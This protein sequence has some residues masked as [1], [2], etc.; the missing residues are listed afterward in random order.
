MIIDL[1]ENAEKYTSVHKRI[2]KAFHYLR[3]T[4]L[5]EAALGKYAIDGD[6]VFAI[7]Q[8]YKTMDTTNEEM[9]THIKYIDVQYMIKGEELVGHALLN[10]QTPSKEYDA[11]NDFM[12]FPDTPSFFTKMETG[13]FMVFFPTD[14]HMPCIKVHDSAMVKKIVVKVKV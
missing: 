9:E 3:T 8:E 14:M 1:L 2:G 11:D 4:D 12:L 7:V 10:G 6:D 13:T 5:N